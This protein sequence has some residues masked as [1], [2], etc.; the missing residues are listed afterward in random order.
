[1]SSP[2][3]STLDGEYEYETVPAKL[4]CGSIPP[5]WLNSAMLSAVKNTLNDFILAFDMTLDGIV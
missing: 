4:Y 1:M 5:R 2:R 3:A